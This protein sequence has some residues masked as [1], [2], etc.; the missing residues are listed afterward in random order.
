MTC[1]RPTHHHRHPTL[2]AAAVGLAV[3]AAGPAGAESMLGDQS[4]ERAGTARTPVQSVTR[5]SRTATDWSVALPA[6]VDVDIVEEYTA[7]VPGVEKVQ[8]RKMT[9]APGATLANF[10]ISDQLYCMAAEGD[11]SVVDHTRGT[12]AT[13]STGDHW[14]YPAGTYTLSN[15]GAVEHAHYFYAMVMRPVEAWQPAGD[16]RAPYMGKL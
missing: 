11:I 2:A 14:T 6:G 13:Y 1:H 5:I 8:L 9:L 3:L 15:P 16:R 12:A 10:T 7:D 4:F